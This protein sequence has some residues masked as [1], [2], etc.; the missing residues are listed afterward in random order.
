MTQGIHQALTVAPPIPHYIED[1]ILDKSAGNWTTW[2]NAVLAC[3][4]VVGLQGYV[5]GTIPC[6]D[7]A[8]DLTSARNWHTN[9]RAVVSFLGFMVSRSEQP[10]VMDH[11]A[12]GA[13]AVWDAL[14]ARHFDAGAQIRLIHEAFSVR[15]GAESP[16]A[17]SAR[18]DELVA[19][20]FAL[21]PISSK[22]LVSAVMVNAVQGDI[23]NLS[24]V[25]PQPSTSK[26]PQHN[27]NVHRNRVS[28]EQNAISAITVEASTVQHELSPAVAAFLQNSWTDE[29]EWIRLLE[30]LF[31]ALGRIDAIPIASEWDRAIAAK[32]EVIAEV[33]ILRTKLETSE[34]N[35]AV[36]EEPHDEGEQDGLAAIAT[37][38]SNVQT[39]LAPAV[40]D[41]LQQEPDERQR[42]RLIELLVQTLVRLDNTSMHLDWEEGRIKRKRAVDEVLRLLN[43]LEWSPASEPSAAPTA[44]THIISGPEQDMIAVI[45]AEL[46]N[47]Q[48][49]LA[50]AVATFP[51]SA[52]L[53]DAE[54]ER[55]HLS[56][57]LFETVER[58]DATRINL[59]WEQARK[60]RRNAVREA[61]T[62]QSKL[63][64][65]PTCTEEQDA[66]TK[67]A[68]ER[69]KIQFLLFPA[70]TSYLGNPT[71]LKE[72]LRLS[73]LL[74]QA[75]E[76]LDGFTLES[77]WDQARMERKEVVNEVQRLQDRLTQ[78]SPTKT[79]EE[80]KALHLITSQ[81]SHIQFLF[82][83]AVKSFLDKP[84]EK[85]RARLSEL[86]LQTLRRL[87][88]MSIPLEWDEVRQARRDA[89]LELQKLQDMCN[90]PPPPAQVYEE[91]NAI[92]AIASQRSKIQNE[93]A[94]AV[95][96][97]VR[98]FQPSALPT[99]PGA[100]KP[101]EKERLR[102]S[103]LSLR[104]LE[105]LD[106]VAVESGWDEARRDRKSAVGEVQKLQDML[107]VWGL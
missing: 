58:L 106:A 44:L 15:Y 13:K 6:P 85:E 83:P 56:R 40:A 80:K 31:Q 74:L 101:N 35:A 14:L 4:T 87:D 65:L 42:A 27:P 1:I 57:L 102:L 60:E 73:E 100:Q 41:Y 55:R 63:D 51:R 88:A 68:S 23:D 76:R 33:Q 16:A 36:A 11:A 92:A 62:L 5:T 18:I 82:T 99:S 17:T 71:N 86:F 48:N 3:L 32:Q 54:R 70:V 81:R 95:F 9:D 2:Q 69:S 78:A 77:A 91:P 28:P 96:L 105:S 97:F 43:T 89:V 107:D 10:F 20:I 19:R 29:A 24:G 47:V 104:F 30:L 21:G 12:A 67:I 26:Q 84:T 49:V 90:P 8:V 61:E 98:T 59:D 7:P 37:E 34:T 38:M 22:T 93:L 53:P 79:D 50:P 94:P 45:A 52:A 75:L 72:Q 46:S 64:G 66:I 39:Q 25:R 103:E